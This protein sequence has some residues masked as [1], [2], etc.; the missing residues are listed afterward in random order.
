MK[1]KR[2]IRIIAIMAILTTSAN[3]SIPIM[4]QASFESFNVG[5]IAGQEYWHVYGGTAEIKNQSGWFFGDKWL[6]VYKSDGSS[7]NCKRVFGARESLKVVFYAKSATTEQNG[8][9]YV[10][11]GLKYAVKFGFNS[12]GKFFTYHST[13][14]KIGSYSY[15]AY[16]TY[17]FVVYAYAGSKK[18]TIKIYDP[19]GNMVQTFQKYSFS[20]SSCGNTLNTFSIIRPTGHAV[21]LDD[22]KIYE[23]IE[24]VNVNDDFGFNASD[25]TSYIQAAIDSGASKVTIP[26]IGQ[27][28]ISG[29]LTLLDDQELRLDSGVLLMAKSGAFGTYDS[30][31]TA[32]KLYNVKVIGYGA[33]I[34]MRKGSYGS[35]QW[36]HGI[37]LDGVRG[38]EIKGLKVRLTGGDGVY[39]G[40]GG[41]SRPYSE[42]IVIQTVRVDECKRNAISVI[43]VENLI[44]NDCLLEDTAGNSP[45]DGIDIEPNYDDEILKNVLIKNSTIQNNA[46]PG[47]QINIGK[48]SSSSEFVDIT[49]DNVLIRGTVGSSSYSSCGLLFNRCKNNVDGLITVKN[50]TIEHSVGPAVIIKNKAANGVL[51][52]FNNTSFESGLNTYLYPFVFIMD[53][54]TYTSSIGGVDFENGCIIIDNVDRCFM[55]YK[56]DIAGSYEPTAIS[57]EI[58]VDN[59]EAFEWNLNYAGVTLDAEWLND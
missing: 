4:Y 26:N 30:F 33:E 49:I 10:R 6:K 55:Y 19:D 5:S 53:S 15:S 36:I 3:A 50:S 58:D 41:F 47:I 37:R 59:P 35:S 9:F 42:D 51:I 45:R 7:G 28:W 8:F 57:G 17:K 29:P 32:D 1:I 27:T 11:D 43:S 25:S 23:I 54:T 56:Q 39:V 13:I 2:L 22:L 14:K 18:F 16:V 12:D 48:L 24:N 40:S 52:R 46:G 38:A 20:D 44:I 31:L 34:R 21:H